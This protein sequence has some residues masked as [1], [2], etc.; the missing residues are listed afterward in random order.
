N[1]SCKRHTRGLEPPA[2]RMIP[3]VPH[4]PAVARMI[5]ARQTC[6]C[7]LLRSATTAANRSRS[8]ALTS[9]LIPSRIR[10]HSTGSATLESYVCVRPLG[11]GLG[12]LGGALATAPYYSSYDYAP[13]VGT[14]A[15]TVW[16]C[17]DNYQG[18]YRA[19]PQC[20]VPWQEVLQ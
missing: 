15:P 18:Y 1:G 5:R 9:M 8:A 13:Y 14:P 2:G 20:P 6:F 12:L 19:V 4:P 7:G 17:C 11:V 16:Y 3:A 10:H